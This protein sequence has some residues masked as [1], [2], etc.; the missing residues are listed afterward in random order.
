MRNHKVL[1]LPIGSLIFL[2]VLLFLGGCNSNKQGVTDTAMLSKPSMSE[3]KLTGDE[4]KALL[5]G[6]TYHWKHVTRSDSGKSYFNP[7]GSSK[8]AKNGN[9]GKSGWAI[10][11]DQL[12]FTGNKKI[13]RDV[14]ADGKRA[15]YL[16][17]NGSKR[18]VK[19][20]KIEQGDKL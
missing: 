1:L 5:V 2:S 20:F 10:K 3:K 13:C 14:Q 8:W 16:V 7:D 4:I 15:Y 12:C 9:S 18:V 6:N 17:K 11:G 19:I